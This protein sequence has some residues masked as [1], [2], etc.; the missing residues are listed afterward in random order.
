MDKEIIIKEKRL[1]KGKIIV[2]VILI[3]AL[4]GS[5]AIFAAVQRQQPN[6]LIIQGSV[7]MEE[8]N[9]NSKLA[10][11]IEEV[12]VQ[13]GDLV[14]AGDPLI[15]LTSETVEAKLQQA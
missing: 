10:G 3:I 4:L 15:K 8:T 2:G 1:S 11:T 14:K 5:S 12:F 9:L 6:Q 13:E 7:K